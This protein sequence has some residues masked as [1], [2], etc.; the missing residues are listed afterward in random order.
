M[1]IEIMGL[2][3]LLLLS[4]FFSSSELAYV[5]SNKLKNVE[6]RIKGRN[7]NSSIYIGYAAKIMIIITML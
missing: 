4:G 3:A 1:T 2:L 6:S 7:V 5:V